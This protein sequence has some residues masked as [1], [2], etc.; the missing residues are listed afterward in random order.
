MDRGYRVECLRMRSIDSE[1]KLI[2]TAMGGHKVPMSRG[3]VDKL[4]IKYFS[5]SGEENDTYS[6]KYPRM[7]IAG[8]PLED[9]W[10]VVGDECDFELGGKD[11]C[12]DVFEELQEDEV[13]SKD[14]GSSD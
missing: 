10:V 6:T 2:H 4:E 3:S 8:K 9:D 11:N 14:C 7:C 13:I 12:G 1:D 5:T